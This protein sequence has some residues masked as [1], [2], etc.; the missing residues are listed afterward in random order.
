M[1]ISSEFTA[2]EVCPDTSFA[3]RSRE[4]REIFQFVLS[5]KVQSRFNIASHRREKS[6]TPVGSSRMSRER[7]VIQTEPSAVL[8]SL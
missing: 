3:S 2:V 5:A 7:K 8:I 6:F 1:S 4:I